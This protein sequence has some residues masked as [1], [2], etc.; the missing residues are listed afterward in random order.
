MH[1]GYLYALGRY[2]MVTGVVNTV[3]YSRIN[4]DGTLREWTYTSPFVSSRWRHSSVAYNGHL[5]AIGGMAPTITNAVEVARIVT[6]DSDAV[7]SRFFLRGAYSHLVDLGN[8]G[9]VK[10]IFLSGPLAPGGKV[11]LQIRLA[12]DDAVLDN[13]KTL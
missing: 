2:D 10:S 4:A 13:E 12:A 1:N 5:Y 6:V 9:P 11:N 3:E 8:D 7:Q